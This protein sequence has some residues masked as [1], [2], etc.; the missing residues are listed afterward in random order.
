MTADKQPSQT[1][2]CCDCLETYFAGAHAGPG[3]FVCELCGQPLTLRPEG[4]EP[5]QG[6]PKGGS[7]SA[8]LPENGA[9]VA[10]LELAL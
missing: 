6:G 2:E 9:D 3:P 1:W 4:A 5:Y 10:Q 8:S 7:S